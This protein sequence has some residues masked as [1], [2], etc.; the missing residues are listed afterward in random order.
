MSWKVIFLL[1]LSGIVVGFAGVFGLNGAAE[2]V[3]WLAVFLVFAIV[4]AKRRDSDY[5]VHGLLSSIIAGFWVGVVHAAFIN[6]FVAH[7][8]QLGAGLAKM[9]RTAHPRLMM[10]IYGPF[11]GAVTGVVAGLMASVA[12]KFVKRAQ[13][14]M[15]KQGS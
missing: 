5:F 3:V 1:S 13:S 4:I 10:V 7:N 6:T 11:I 9:P 14:P 2:I 12:G 8:P 15:S